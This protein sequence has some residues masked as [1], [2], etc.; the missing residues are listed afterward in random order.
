MC[1]IVYKKQGLQ[2]GKATLKQMW[3][4]NKDGAGLAYHLPNGKVMVDKGYSKYEDFESAV[5]DL[6]DHA[7][8]MHFR[9]ATHGETNALQTH[10]FVISDSIEK[11][12]LLKGEADAVLF[13]NGVIS[14]FGDKKYSDTLEFV[15]S[16]LARTEDLKLRTEILKLVSGSRFIIMQ[17]GETWMM[18]GF[19][20]YKGL[21]VSNMYFVTG[22]TRS[23][24]TYGSTYTPYRGNYGLYGSRYDDE[25]W[26]YD[27]ETRTYKYTPVKKAAVGGADTEDAE[28]DTAGS[29]D[30]E[31]GVIE[32]GSSDTDDETIDDYI[33][34]C[35]PL[36]LETDEEIIR[37]SITEADYYAALHAGESDFRGIC[38]H[39][40]E[41]DQPC[42]L[43]S[44]HVH[45]LFF[46]PEDP[47]YSY[48]SECIRDFV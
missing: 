4:A 12:K 8:V 18:N 13:H 3:D 23:V 16:V 5:M 22:R 43:C 42:A 45:H 38:V 47:D 6:Q 1:V 32:A 26:T 48:C 20:T 11:S 30:S 25:D 28:D 29:Q 31:P 10:P 35:D 33:D 2:I 37:R 14:G 7:L 36:I 40:D 17:D 19:D 34:D 15:T 9:I 24:T 41:R 39:D 21:K 44:Y 27:R 46:L